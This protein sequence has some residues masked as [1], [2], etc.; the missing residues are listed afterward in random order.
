[1]SDRQ[2]V[3]I[4]RLRED[5]LG[6][7]LSGGDLDS[8]TAVGETE[9]DSVTGLLTR[10]FCDAV[11]I[12]QYKHMK[13]RGD[14]LFAI[15]MI[16]LDE[17]KFINDTYGHPIGDDVLKAWGSSVLGRFR[18]ADIKGRFGGDEIII[19]MTDYKSKADKQPQDE[20]KIIY[21]D[22]VKKAREILS[23]G[24]KTKDIPPEQIEAS[25]GMAVW[26][27]EESLKEVIDRADKL[28][29]VQKQA[30]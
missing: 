29:Y 23:Q 4:K 16:D 8:G 7:D 27:G 3:D 20:E 22:L 25:V 24:E 14:E 21:K 28:L 1:M 12:Q 17:F 26:D 9:I 11:M 30:K 15:V 5:L 18:E 6:V 19:M 2:E 13:R 10:T